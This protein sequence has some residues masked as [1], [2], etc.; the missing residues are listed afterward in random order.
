MA[1]LLITS[2]ELY[3]LAKRANLPFKIQ[4]IGGQLVIS[5]TVEKIIVMRFRAV[6]EFRKLSETQLTLE[7]VETAPSAGAIG[8]WM[9]SQLFKWLDFNEE[10]PA[11]FFYPYISIDLKALPG[12]DQVSDWIT[13]TALDFEPQG[14]RVSF[15]INED[16]F[17]NRTTDRQT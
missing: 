11:H 14:I 8:D 9:K 16:K 1:E 15:I 17:S 7:I 10:L 4:Y 2:D 13:I 3:R 6:A 5:G 12:W